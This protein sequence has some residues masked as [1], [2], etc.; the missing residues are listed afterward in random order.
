MKGARRAMGGM[1]TMAE[2]VSM[3]ESPSERKV[4]RWMTGAMTVRLSQERRPTLFLGYGS[5]ER[6]RVPRMDLMDQSMNRR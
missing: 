4:D 1:D 5:K 3:V 6:K 2:R